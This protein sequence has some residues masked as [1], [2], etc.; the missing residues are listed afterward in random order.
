M[1]QS[2]DDLMD[3]EGDD[4]AEAEPRWWSPTGLLTPEASAITALTL[5]VVGVIGG[6]FIGFPVAQA[7][8]G[9]GD[10]PD[11]MRM[12]NVVSAAIVLL[13]LL[14]TIWLARR[15]LLDDDVEASVWCRH[16]AGS[17]VIVAAVGSAL[18]AVTIIGGLLQRA[19]F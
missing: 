4:L 8:V 2:D 3:Y 16:L 19:D 10:G 1:N 11:D 18:S 17:A 13:L 12:H 7:L 14:G 9:F 5:A 6:G 15:V